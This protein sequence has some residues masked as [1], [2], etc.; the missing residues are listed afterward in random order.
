MEEEGFKEKED[1]KEQE[2]NEKNTSMT[3]S[4]MTSSII[5][6]IWTCAISHVVAEP[7]RPCLRVIDDIISSILDYLDSSRSIS[8]GKQQ[9]INIKQQK[10][11]DRRQQH[12][13]ELLAQ[14]QG[15]SA[16]AHQGPAVQ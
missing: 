9:H 16:F 7:R 6:H 11:T 14:H 4:T 13:A 8:N 1:I 3:T 10:R 15:A 5:H 12:Q 2:P